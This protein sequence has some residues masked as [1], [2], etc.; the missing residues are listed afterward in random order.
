MVISNLSVLSSSNINSFNRIPVTAPITAPVLG[1]LF[2]GA[3]L[4]QKW[5]P[6]SSIVTRYVSVQTHV[7][8]YIIN[9]SGGFALYVFNGLPNMPVPTYLL[10]RT[11]EFCMHMKTAFA[12]R[13]FL[14]NIWSAI[15]SQDLKF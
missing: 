1:V 12:Q 11:V 7:S 5:D 3:Y 8:F 10:K 13:S 15:H 14:F 6:K 4:P 9:R 2:R